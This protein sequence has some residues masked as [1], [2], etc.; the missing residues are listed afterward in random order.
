MA[1]PAQFGG[2][3]VSCGE[4]IRVD[5]PIRMTDAGA[6]HDDCDSVPTTDPLATIHPVCQTCWLT[7]PNGE[8]DR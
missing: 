5:D 6:V 1:F 3:C 4:G 2:K 7:H 8:C